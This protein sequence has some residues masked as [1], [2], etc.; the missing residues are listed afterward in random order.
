MNGRKIC[1]VCGQD[2]PHSEYHRA[3]KKPD[4]IQHACKP[5]TLA[6]PKRKI[7]QRKYESKMRRLGPHGSRKR[8]PRIPD[9]IPTP[10]P[11]TKETDHGPS[12]PPSR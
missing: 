2:K 7:A 3:T 10:P 6:D 12:D 9:N 1:P 4:G 11:P 5:C 8:T